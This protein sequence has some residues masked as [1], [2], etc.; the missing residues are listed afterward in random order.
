MAAAAVQ[1]DTFRHELWRAF[2]DLPLDG[3]LHLWPNPVHAIRRY[4][5]V[6]DSL[7]QAERIKKIPE[8]PVR[9]PI[10]L[11]QAGCPVMPSWNAGSKYSKISRQLLSCL[12]FRSSTS[13]FRPVR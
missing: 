12:F 5:P 8:V 4:E 2:R 11:A 10:V 3:L 9:I 13:T 6:V 1:D 7:F